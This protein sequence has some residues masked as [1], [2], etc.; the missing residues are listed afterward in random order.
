MYEIEIGVCEVCGKKNVP[1]NRKYYDYPDVKC[2][3]HSP[4]HFDLV[5]YCNDCKPKQPTYTRIQVR[6]D[7]LRTE[8]SVSDA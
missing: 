7:S 3:C 5:R 6:T 2:E 1:L 8:R 4:H